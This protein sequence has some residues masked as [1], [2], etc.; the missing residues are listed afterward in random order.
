MNDGDPELEDDHDDDL[1]K[2]R[3]DSELHG[4]AEGLLV[5]EG[6]PVSERLF[7]TLFVC[8]SVFCE[9]CVRVL[10][11]LIEGVCAAVGEGADENDTCEE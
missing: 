6:E 7:D 3:F 4:L 8:E 5:K 10:N 11:E 2:N 1:V 9:D